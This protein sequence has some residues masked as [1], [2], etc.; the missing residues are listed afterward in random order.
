M[1]LISWY[2]QVHVVKYTFGIQDLPL[3][4]PLGVRKPILLN[5]NIIILGTYN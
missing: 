1:T 3:I 5:N 4:P 2:W